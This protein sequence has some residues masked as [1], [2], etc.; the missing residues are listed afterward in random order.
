[1]ENAKWLLLFAFICVKAVGNIYILADAYRSGK[2]KVYSYDSFPLLGAKPIRDH[3]LA[4][5]PGYFWFE[6]LSNL[7][8]P[9]AIPLLVYISV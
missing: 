2:I 7:L 5:E 8:W 1:M 9:A 6:V 4:F 3:S